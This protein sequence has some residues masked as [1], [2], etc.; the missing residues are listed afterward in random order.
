MCRVERFTKAII[1]TGHH[2]INIVSK[3]DVA[4]KLEATD[5][6]Y[7]HVEHEYQVYRNLV[8]GIGI[9]TVYWFGS[10]CDYNVM[11]LE[12]LGPSLGNLFDRYHC[13]FTLLTVLLLVDQLV[14]V[15]DCFNRKVGT[16]LIPITQISCIEYVH[17]R[18]FI[19]SDI[20]PSNILMGVGNH[21]DQVYIINFS[22]A[23][24]Y[25]DLKN[26]LHILC[27]TN[28]DITG[29]ISYALINNCRGI[30]PSHRDDLESITYVL[31]FFMHGSLPW[32]GIEPAINKQRHDTILQTKLNTPIKILCSMCPIEFNVF[33]SYIHTL[34]FEDKPDYAYICKLFHNVFIREG[35]HQGHPF[36]GYN[37]ANK[38]NPTIRTGTKCSGLRAKECGAQP[39]SGRM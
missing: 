7:S 3:L 4:I 5:T 18:H 39:T 15:Q 11:V 32:H 14:S 30:S 22:L 16:P 2:R 33:L 37:S 9:P 26:R 25:R 19:H 27:Q 24:R 38:Q 6:E 35:C 23:M 17:S 20:K 21:D 1:G 36:A 31:P 8:G 13:K 34:S 28:C 10:E 12:H 29:T